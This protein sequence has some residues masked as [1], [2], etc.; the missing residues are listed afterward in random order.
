MSSDKIIQEITY[1]ADDGEN[2]TNCD[3]C[4]NFV[5]ERYHKNYLK[6]GTHINNNHETQRIKISSCFKHNKCIY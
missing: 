1:C 6:S 5:I 3:I 2:R 4:E